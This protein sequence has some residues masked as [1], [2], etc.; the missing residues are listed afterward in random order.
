MKKLLSDTYKNVFI[1]NKT[2]F[3][4][5]LIRTA[6]NSYGN[7]IYENKLLHLISMI[8]EHKDKSLLSAICLLLNVE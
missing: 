7:V 4:C 6:K 1:S 2:N 3:L 5:E 8:V